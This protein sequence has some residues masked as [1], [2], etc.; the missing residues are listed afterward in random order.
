[1]MDEIRITDDRGEFGFSWIVD[2]WIQRCSHALVADG[3]VWLVDPVDD[4]AIIDRAC[5]L[6]EPAGVLQLLDRHRRDGPQIADRLGV[7]V[8]VCPTVLEESPFEFGRVV[9]RPWWRE[10]SLWWSERRLLVV[11]EAV[12]TAEYFTVGRGLAGVHPLLRLRPPRTLARY[13]P[14][15][16]LV[17]HGT[18]L[19]A[20]NASD[21]LEHAIADARRGIGALMATTVR[22]RRR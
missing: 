5:A 7:P 17:G 13:S 4:P 20:G 6:G 18:G 9:W 3:R 22:G 11:P 8:H 12:G 16:L 14:E 15:T 19:H 2:E 21:A 10:V 1:M